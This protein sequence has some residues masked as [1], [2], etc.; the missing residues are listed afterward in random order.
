MK[1]KTKKGAFNVNSGVLTMLSISI[2]TIV[3]LVVTILFLVLK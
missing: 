1:K 3:I 2:L